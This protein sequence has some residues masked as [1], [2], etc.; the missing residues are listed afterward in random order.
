MQDN[1][2]GRKSVVAMDVVRECGFDLINYPPYSSDVAPSI[3]TL[4]PNMETK[5]AG[6]QMMMMRFA[7]AI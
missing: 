5:L 6:K 1:A 3:D 7:V 4:F 2:L